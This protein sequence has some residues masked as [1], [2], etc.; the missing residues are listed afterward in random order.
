MK[1]KKEGFDDDSDDD[2]DVEEYELTLGEDET[3]D[4][5]DVAGDDMVFGS[6][7]VL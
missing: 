1:R 4:I 3:I 7:E 5:E 2:F 6:D